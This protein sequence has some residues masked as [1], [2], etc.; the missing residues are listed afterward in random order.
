M[1][2]RVTWEGNA[3]GKRMPVPGDAPCT[4]LIAPWLT[5]TTSTPSGY[6]SCFRP[7]IPII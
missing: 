7:L 2:F 4:M 3:G 6:A 1:P 5:P